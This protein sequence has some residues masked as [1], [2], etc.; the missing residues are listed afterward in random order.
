MSSWR[1]FSLSW[2]EQQGLYSTCPLGFRPPPHL[3]SCI[4]CLLRQELNLKCLNTFK[5]LKFNQPSYIRELLSF[6]SHES[7]S[8][9]R[10]ADDPYRLHEPI[11]IGERGFANHS[12]FY[13][14]PHLYNKLPVTVKQIDS[15]NTFKSHLKAFLF[16]LALRSIRSYCSGGLCTVNFGGCLLA[17]PV[18][19]AIW[20]CRRSFFFSFATILSGPYLWNRYS[21]RLQIECAA[22]SCGLILHCCLPSNSLCYFF[23]FYFFPPRFCPGHISGTVTRR[24]SKLSVLLGP[25]V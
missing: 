23:Y 14:D 15:L 7:T 22:W 10:S 11:A 3:L 24:D 16:S 25:A 13:I 17:I 18:G 8:G 2:T 20:D 4:G 9:L 12:F 6:S 5:A 19:D 1:R 21:Q